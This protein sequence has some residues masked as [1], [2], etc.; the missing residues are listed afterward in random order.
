MA[1]SRGDVFCVL[2]A[3]MPKRKRIIPHAGAIVV[4]LDGGTPRVVVVTTRNRRDRWVL[5][6]G[7]VKRSE[8][9]RAAAVREAC[10]EAG[11]TGRVISLVE[12][13]TYSAG[14]QRLRVEYFL[15]RYR[16]QCSKQREERAVRWCAV[17]DAIQLL[18]YASAR[19]VLLVAN[20]RIKNLQSRRSRS[21]A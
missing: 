10:E 17:E 3:H 4:R 21:S 19:R 14:D 16:G 9:G 6:K 5:P 12:A 2:S 1:A 11:V 13:V 15:V 7:R 18:T 20:E 8:T